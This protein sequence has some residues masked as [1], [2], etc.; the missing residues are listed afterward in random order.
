MILW[1]QSINYAKMEQETDLIKNINLIHS[2]ELGIF[3]IRKNLNLDSGQDAVA[4]CKNKITDKNCKI[5]KQGKNRYCITDNIIITVN[6]HS[7]TVITA[8]TGK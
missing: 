4:Y 6:A 1:G 5:Y 7:Y 8:H 2:T 3:R